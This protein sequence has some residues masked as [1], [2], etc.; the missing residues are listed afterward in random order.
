ME[1][2]TSAPSP[3]CVKS[4]SSVFNVTGKFSLPCTANTTHSRA[5]PSYLSVMG[6]KHFHVLIGLQMKLSR[7]ISEKLEIPL[8]LVTKQNGTSGNSVVTA[9]IKASLQNVVIRVFISGRY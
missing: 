2:N 4:R 9:K 7:D 5:C 6:I 1:R 8:K 3:S